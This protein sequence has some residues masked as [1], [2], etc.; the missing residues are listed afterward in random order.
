MLLAAV[1]VAYQEKRAFVGAVL[2]KDGALIEEIGLEY[3][4]EVAEY[5][6]GAFAER[7]A[8]CALMALNK[9]MS[10][11]DLLLIDGQGR[12]HPRRFGLACHLGKELQWPTVGVAKNLLCGQHGT[13]AE[14]RGAYEMITD[15]DEVIGAVVRTRASVKPVY[16]SV[17]FG[18]ELERAIECVLACSRYRI[19]EPLR[20]AH[21]M[22]VKTRQRALGD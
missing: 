17:G 13:L 15:E 19:P 20:E 2:M 21:G 16:V 10:Q 9:L 1:D 11:P 3:P 12:A 18:I 7:E 4:G 5:Q 14:E 22:S 8:P 6:P